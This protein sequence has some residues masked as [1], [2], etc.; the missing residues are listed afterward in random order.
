[1]QPNEN[2]SSSSGTQPSL[3]PGLRV[4]SPK[5]W[6][7][8]VAHYQPRLIAWCRSRGLDDAATHDVLQ[9]VWVSVARS[10][11]GFSSTTG[12]G[13]FRAW[14]W[15]IMQRRI[16]D[17]RRQQGQEPGGTGGSTMLGRL[18]RVPA[19]SESDSG[20]NSNTYDQNSE[21]SGTRQRGSHK[22][23]L[24]TAL[25]QILDRVQMDYEP[26]T[27]QAF[28]R[29]VMDGH[30]TEQVATEF[31]MTAVGVRQLRSR[32]LRRLRSELEPREP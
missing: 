31:N 9:E 7:R 21:D 10:L 6:E 16:I 14:L 22:L 2:P 5:A 23:Q 26:R 19:T 8:L 18:A 1:M 15:R 28:L 13:A 4:G 17:Y 32:I 25:K 30:S 24:N 11:P 12:N 27:W 3:V 29:C 20:S